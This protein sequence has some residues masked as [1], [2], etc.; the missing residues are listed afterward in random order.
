MSYD[1]KEIYNLI[2]DLEERQENYK[3]VQRN[4]ETGYSQRCTLCNLENLEEIEEYRENG[5]TYEEIKEHFNLKISIMSISRHFKNHY[6]KSKEYKQKRKL[7]LFKNIWECYMQFPFLEQYFKNKKLEELESFN[8]SK[9]F[10]LDKFG[11]CEYIPNSTVSCGCE[12]ID[13]LKER[14]QQEIQEYRDKYYYLRDDTSHISKK[15]KDILINC[16]NCRNNIN[17]ERL[18]LLERIVGYNF[19]NIPVEKQELY[20]QLLHYNGNSEEFIKTISE[21]VGK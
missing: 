19:L 4:K 3:R 6:P 12:T 9:G 13:S 17:N 15:Y 21:P 1:L 7:E 11:L 16:L 8:S 14:E 2:K 5:H 20:F 18:S 10:C